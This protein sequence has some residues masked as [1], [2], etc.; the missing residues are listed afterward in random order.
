[1]FNSGAFAAFG[2]R[3]PRF[4]VP[5]PGKR[6]DVNPIHQGVVDQHS[7]R[8]DG[9]PVPLLKPAPGEPG[10]AVRGGGHRL[11]EGGVAHPGQGGDEKQAHRVLPVVQP[12]ALL[13]LLLSGQG[14]GKVALKG[15]HTVQAAVA[16]GAVVPHHRVGGV[17]GVELHRRA[18]YD[19]LAQLGHGVGGP[20][21]AVEK[22]EEKGKP[23]LPAGGQ[24]AGD[25]H[26]H[27]HPGVGVGHGAEIGEM[28]PAGPAL[29]ADGMAACAHGF[30]AP[31]SSRV[32]PPMAPS[33]GRA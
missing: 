3:R 20:P 1:M 21:G 27:R 10:I 25:V 5:A 26:L 14:G 19:A 23:R 9:P 4:P 30:C 29:Q 13:G 12:A 22:A 8:H 18:V 11:A 33:R 32:S 16:V 17:A 28:L 31:F 2:L 6:S 7:H 24:E 15:L